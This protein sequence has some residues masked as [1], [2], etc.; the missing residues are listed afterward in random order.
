MN[1]VI[2]EDSE[3]V[4]NQLLRM[5][6]QKPGVRVAG[7]ASDE[8]TAVSIIVSERPDA[9]LMDLALSVGNG[10]KV[11]ERVRAAG[12]ECRVLVLTNNISDAFRQVCMKYGISGFYD[13]SRDVEA[14]LDKLFSWVGAFEDV[15]IPAESDANKLDELPG[16][17][18]H[19]PPSAQEGES[20]GLFVIDVSPVPM[21]IIDD[22]GNITHLNAA[23]IKSFGYQLEDIPTL[24]IPSKI[25]SLNS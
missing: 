2:V 5:L 24:R 19:Y 10:M 12:I 22:F 20:H 3:L 16:M 11:L 13:K 14:C 8:D 18:D 15:A 1:V 9:V 25:T 17:A 23:F 4:R 21:A 6:R 7:I